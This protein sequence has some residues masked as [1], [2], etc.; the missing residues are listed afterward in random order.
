MFASALVS[1]D[2]LVP[3]DVLLDVSGEIASELAESRPALFEPEMLGPLLDGELAAVQSFAAAL[4]D[5][6]GVPEASTPTFM[7]NVS[8]FWPSVSVTTAVEG[9]V[10]APLA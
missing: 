4:T 7:L 3:V 8:S 2:A 5:S 10:E 1:F 9:V 6:V